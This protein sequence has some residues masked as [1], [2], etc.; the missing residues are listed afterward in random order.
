M[1]QNASPLYIKPKYRQHGVFSPVVIVLMVQAT[2]VTHHYESG[3]GQAGMFNGE[4]LP[5]SY[6]WSPHWASPTYNAVERL[7]WMTSDCVIGGDCGAVSP[8]A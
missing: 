4:A 6:Q 1:A 8:T 5:R 7:E 2:F 3:C